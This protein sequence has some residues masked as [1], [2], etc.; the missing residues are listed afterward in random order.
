MVERGWGRVVNVSARYGLF[1]EGLKG[2]A[3][4]SLSKAALNALTRKLADE[5][6][7][8]VKVNAVSPGWVRTRMGGPAAPR[9]V[10]QGAASVV[11]LA[12][13]GDDGPTGRM[14][15]DDQ[16]VDW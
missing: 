5:V 9:A 15:Y 16:P 11:R 7:A 6:P 1:S 12:T 8:T 14:F 10:E 2:P 3:P 4:Y 13:L